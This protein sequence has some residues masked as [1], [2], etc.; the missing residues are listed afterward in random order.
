M[1]CLFVLAAV[2]S[3]MGV[4]SRA[5][6]QPYAAVDRSMVDP[7]PAKIHLVYG[8]DIR[9]RRLS[10][11]AGLSQTRVASVVQDKVGF[12]WFATQYGLN[13]YDGYKSKVFKNEPGQ[14]ESLSCVYVRSPFMDHTGRLWVGCDKFLDRFV[15]ATETFVHY[16]IDA[17]TSDQQST[18]IER[19]SEDGAGI[20][21]L[22]TGRGLYRFDPASPGTVRLVYGP[23]V[24]TGGAENRINEAE[25]DREGRFW[26]AGV[27]GLEEFDRKAERVVRRASLRAEIGRFREDK[28]GIFWMTQRDPACGLAA[29]NPRTNALRCHSLQFKRR[30]VPSTAEISE[31]LEDRNGT[32]WLS[33]RAGL[34]KFDRAH[35]RILRYHNDPFDSESLESDSIIYLYQDQEGNIWTCFQGMEPSF[36]AERSQ[37]FENF[38][39][40]R[41]SLLDP[42]V[43]SI[44]EDHGGI[45]WIGSMGGL[46]R[47]DRGSDKN[48][49]SPNV[50]NEVL[51]ILEDSKG[52]LLGGTYH[53]G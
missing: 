49:A 50:G 48:I 18:P 31:I 15:P 22:A 38:T 16:R 39:Y 10:A 32:L 13:R 6:L 8:N 45:L 35:N 9:F 44:Y 19:I 41:G 2:L 33:S 36:F 40:Q 34:L 3:S 53:R 7:L 42:L 23:H 21:W 25:E 51:A 30:G 14:P 24:F 43:T 26:V 29:W 47:I 27:A 11:G 37:L 12:L 52:V 5:Q 46:N 1:R 17:E 4:E 28:F 20:L